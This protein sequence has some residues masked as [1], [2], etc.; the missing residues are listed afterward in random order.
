MLNVEET[1]SYK[2]IK[3]IVSESDFIKLQDEY[4]SLSNQTKNNKKNK[5]KE[6]DN[7]NDF[8]SEVSDIITQLTNSN[9]IINT[10]NFLVLI[11]ETYPNIILSRILKK[12]SVVG[13]TIEESLFG[14]MLEIKQTTQKPLKQKQHEQL[15]NKI[16]DDFLTIATV[17]IDIKYKNIH[18]N[19]AG[20]NT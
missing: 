1:Y 2:I 19:L 15:S 11:L 18:A 17:N 13:D 20:R 7:I 5:T 14:K 12:Y 10:A 16:E 6:S 8:S 9:D 4:Y 3:E